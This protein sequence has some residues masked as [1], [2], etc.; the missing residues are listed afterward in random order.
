VER[1]LTM[2]ERLSDE[3]LMHAYI[4]AKALNLDS[5]FISLLKKEIEK[6]KLL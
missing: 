5:D 3:I 1:T 4:Q 6:R 2:L